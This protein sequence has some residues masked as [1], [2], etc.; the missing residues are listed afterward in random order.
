M[1]GV[2]VRVPNH[3]SPITSVRFL[4]SPTVH[5]SLNDDGK[6]TVSAISVDTGGLVNMVTFGRTMLRWSTW[7]VD[8]SCL[9]DGSAGQILAEHV[10][11]PYC[12]C[13]GG[14]GNGRRRGC[15]KVGE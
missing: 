8:C 1:V 2:R 7:N 4:Y 10:M 11:S 14:G 9:L 5:S 12:P 3:P 15:G 13:K 6:G